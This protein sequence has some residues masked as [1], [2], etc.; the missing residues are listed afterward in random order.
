MES[1]LSAEEVW[2]TARAVADR[3]P[4]EARLNDWFDALVDALAT[5]IVET[6]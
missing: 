4:T 3:V 1:G 2:Q 6:V 5:R